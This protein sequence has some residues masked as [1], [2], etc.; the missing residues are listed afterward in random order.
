MID[1][2]LKSV[3]EPRETIAR[4]LAMNVDPATL[5]KLALLVAAISGVI[6]AISRTVL[7]LP[8]AYSSSLLSSPIF[9]AGLQ[10]F[11]IF[12]VAFL[13]HRIGRLFDG[14]GDLIGAL[15][16]SIW[17]AFIWLFTVV[18][19]ILLILLL[20]TIAPLAQLIIL[21]WMLGVFTR[22]VQEL[23][24]FENFIATLGG[25][26]GA[27]FLLGIILVVLLISLGAVPLG[28]S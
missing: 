24:G 10:F 20:P 21:V 14:R 22:F 12:I 2:V 13:V 3:T 17:F 8:E 26:I 5:Y 4:V 28:A 11:G 18:F 23:H 15:R 16:I 7:P 19:V 25:V 6:D 1:L 27:G 9:L